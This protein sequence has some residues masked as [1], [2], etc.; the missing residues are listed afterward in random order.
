MEVYTDCLRKAL[1]KRGLP[2]KLYVDNGAAFRSHHLE[3][4]TASLGIALIHSKPYQ[5][6][7]GGK[8]ERFFRTVRTQFLI[9]IE[10]G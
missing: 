8:I 6:E 2:R 9:R 4:I 3:N 1:A 10:D 7:G 5:P